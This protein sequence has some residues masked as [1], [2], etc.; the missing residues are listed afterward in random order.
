MPDQ[1]LKD[2]ARQFGLS[3]CDRCG[4]CAAVCPMRKVYPDF[5][6][7]HAPRTTI[8]RLLLSSALRPAVPLTDL[9]EDDSLWMCLTCDACLDVCPQEV[10]LRDFVQHLRETALEAGMSDRFAL[11]SRCA[12]PYLPKL[13]VQALASYLPDD[14]SRELL[15]TCPKCRRREFSKKLLSSTHRQASGRFARSPE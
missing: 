13:V 12:R 10:E 11:C 5:D 6:A 1:T 2:A 7:R 3:N 14:Q 15:T 9:L 8:A 4:S